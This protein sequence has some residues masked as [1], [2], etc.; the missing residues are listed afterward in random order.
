MDERVTAVSC[1]LRPASPLPSSQPLPQTL[2][3]PQRA[4]PLQHDHGSS[5]AFPSERVNNTSEPS[6]AYV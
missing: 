1:H 3:L 4:A 2:L 5:L 6:C